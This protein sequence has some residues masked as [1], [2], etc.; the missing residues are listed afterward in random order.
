MTIPYVNDPCIH[1]FCVELCVF[2][3]LPAPPSPCAG[4]PLPDHPPDRP[5]FRSFFPLAPNFTLFSLPGV[6]SLNCG[7]GLRPWTTQI[8]RLGSL[9]PQGAL[10]LYFCSVPM[11]FFVPFFFCPECFFCPVCHFSCCPACRFFCPVVFFSWSPVHFLFSPN[12]SSLLLSRSRCFLVPWFLFWSRD[13]PCAPH[14]A[15]CST[16][17]NKERSAKP[18]WK[19]WKKRSFEKWKKGPKKTNTRFISPFGPCF[20]FFEKKSSTE[21]CGASWPCLAWRL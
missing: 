5:T 2:F 17:R 18:K 12:S 4:P 19:T 16:R 20:F 13:P 6:F 21:V 15:L 14:I 11:F 8:A 1:R 10:S 7:L 3:S 9:V